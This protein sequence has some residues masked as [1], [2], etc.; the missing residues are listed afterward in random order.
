VALAVAALALAGCGAQSGGGAQAGG[1]GAQPG[2]GAQAGGGGARVG[3]GGPFAWLSPGAA[4]SR[5]PVA[6]IPRGATVS[7]P[8]SWHPAAGDRGTTTA[9]RLDRSGQI[10]GY[11]NLTPQQGGET[12]ANWRTFRVEHNA[13]EGDRNV[14]TLAA[15]GGLRFRSGHGACVKDSYLT[16]SGARYIEFACLVRG[17]VIIGAARPGDWATV[18]PQLER[19]ISSFSG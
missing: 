2:A 3:G 15:A 5:W 16:R 17:T 8:P 12:V 1:G 11:L 14:K 4:P 13:D 7:Y 10:A 18:A 6:R 19:S 9:V